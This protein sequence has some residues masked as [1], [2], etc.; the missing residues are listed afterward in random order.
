MI[1]LKVTKKTGLHPLSRKYSYG[2]TT[3]RWVKLSPPF[4]STFLALTLECYVIT[5]G[6]PTPAS[7]LGA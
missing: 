3:E 4:P 2:K 5:N 7:L 1:T 6:T